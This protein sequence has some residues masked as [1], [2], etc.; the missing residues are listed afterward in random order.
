MKALNKK[1]LFFLFL[2]T[3][4]II[5]KYFIIY[6]KKDKK[7]VRLIIIFLYFK[8]KSIEI[9]ILKKYFFNIY[10]NK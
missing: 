4:R 6:H 7:D 9:K 5:L 10:K 8:P 3:Y 1:I 2:Y